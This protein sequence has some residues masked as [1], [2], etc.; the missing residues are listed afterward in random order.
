[1]EQFIFIFKH[2]Q[3]LDIFFYYNRSNEL[4]PPSLAHNTSTQYTLIKVIITHMNQFSVLT[5]EL[6]PLTQHNV[7]HKEAHPY[8]TYTH[9]RKHTS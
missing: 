8:L 4:Q 5:A 6:Q 1:M 9:T 7:Q 3:T 2:L